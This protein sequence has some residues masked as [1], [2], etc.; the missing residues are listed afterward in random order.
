VKTERKVPLD[1][2]VILDYRVIQEKTDEMVQQE[3]LV[4]MV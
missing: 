1:R 4:K 2:R 3:P